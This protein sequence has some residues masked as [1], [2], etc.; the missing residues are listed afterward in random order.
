L[1]SG[2][3]QPIHPLFHCWKIVF[4]D[5]SH[6]GTCSQEI[7]PGPPS[8]YFTRGGY[9]IGR[10]VFVWVIATHHATEQPIT[11]V[12]LQISKTQTVSTTPIDGIA[13]FAVP[14]P[15]LSTSGAQ[16]RIT[17]YDQQ[18]RKV[19]AWWVYYRSCPNSSASGG[20]C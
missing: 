19:A 5:G 18:H 2:Q 17:L 20:E 14:R 7:E 12:T 9:H 8:P 6:F 1:P 16:H 3:I 10:A 15:G 4:S 11:K 13:V